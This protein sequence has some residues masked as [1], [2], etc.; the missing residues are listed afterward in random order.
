MV[1]APFSAGQRVTATDLNT[2]IIQ[3]TMEWTNLANIGTFA[4][5]F[6]ADARTPRMRKVV[7]LGTEQWE[8][9]GR[10]NITSLAAATSKTAF[11]FNT[12]Y[13][14]GSERGFQQYASNTAFYGMRVS[15]TMGGLL[16]IGVPTGGGSSA[17]GVMLDGIIITDPL[18]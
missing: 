10:I 2:L 1:Y 7:K 13:I 6:T 18:A 11:T 14:V 4:S 5:G 9:E 8:F 3:E 12:G 15:F 17:S 16:S